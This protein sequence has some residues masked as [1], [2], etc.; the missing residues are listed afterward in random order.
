MKLIV[1]VSDGEG[2]SLNDCSDE[3]ERDSVCTNVYDRVI[4]GVLECDTER[5]RDPEAVS[6]SEW[7]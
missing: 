6:S 1:I 2:L 3:K 7:E 4:I 5:D